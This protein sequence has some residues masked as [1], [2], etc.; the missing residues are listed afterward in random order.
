MIMGPVQGEDMLQEQI[1]QLLAKISRQLDHISENQDLILAQIENL[2]REV[3]THHL[4]TIE[5]LERKIEALPLP[6]IPS[7]VIH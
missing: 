2:R 3:K 6:S 5:E 7:S 4:H 1:F